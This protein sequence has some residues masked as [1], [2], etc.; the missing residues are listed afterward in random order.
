MGKGKNTK[1]KYE[2]LLNPKM[3]QKEIINRQPMEITIQNI[4]LTLL[5]SC[6]VAHFVQAE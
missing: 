2:K 1:R 3:L 4:K 6:K 5:N